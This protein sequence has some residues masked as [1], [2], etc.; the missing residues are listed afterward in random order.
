VCGAGGMGA[1]GCV[2]EGIARSLCILKG[3]GQ[4]N[5][6]LDDASIR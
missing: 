4:H 6:M 5:K 3:G 2:A 1:G